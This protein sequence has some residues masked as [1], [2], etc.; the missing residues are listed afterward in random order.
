M[1][2]QVLLLIL[3]IGMAVL[4]QPAYAVEPTMSYYSCLNSSVS[5]HY[6][7]EWTE[8]PAPGDTEHN[9]STSTYCV[10]GCI[11]NT[12]ECEADP[13]DVGFGHLVL[14]LGTFFVIFVFVYLG[15]NMEEERWVLQL[16][17]LILA[18]IFTLANVFIMLEVSDFINTSDI[19][20]V[21]E[22]LY[23]AVIITII[24]TMLYYMLGIIVK[25]FGIMA[26]K[27]MDL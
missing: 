20:N 22:I 18:L 13:A 8:E 12:G 21:L 24:I 23:M 19:T 2:K 14:I 26:N 27:E 9:H 7:Y 5:F 16:L 17:Y 1:H 3:L 11:A 6:L 10:E 4:P 15:T 25:V